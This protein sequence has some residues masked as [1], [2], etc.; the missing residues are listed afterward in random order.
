MDP[1]LVVQLFKSLGQAIHENAATHLAV[2]ELLHE[3]GVLTDADVSILEKRREKWLAFIEEQQAA[4]EGQAMEWL[5]KEAPN[6]ADLIEALLGK[7]TMGEAL[8]IKPKD[9]PK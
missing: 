4:E 8:G 2:V 6:T 9:E 5:R 3:K 7:K 1:M